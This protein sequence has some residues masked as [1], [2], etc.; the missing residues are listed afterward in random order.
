MN[1]PISDN[2]KAILL[3][4]APLLAGGGQRNGARILTISEYNQLARL[5]QERNA[6]PA[7]LLSSS[8]PA[9]LADLRLRFDTRRLDELLAR[10]FLL[11][12]AVETWNSR[13][14]RVA[15][16]ADPDYPGRF[17]VRLGLDAPPVLYGC[18]D[19]SLLDSGGLAVVGSR[20]VDEK[21]IE[22]A[23]K[24]AST[25]AAAGILVI[26]GG[27]KGID[28]AAMQGSLLAGGRAIGIVAD[29]LGQA[30]VARDSRDPIRE[31]RLTL[32][33]P[34]DPAAGFNVGNAMQ[35]NKLIYALADVA[36]V[37]N[38][39]HEKGGTWSGAIEQIERFRA[40]PVFVRSGEDVP[41]GNK[42]LIEAG[43]RP[44]PNPT[45]AKDLISLLRDAPSTISTIS[46][47]EQE[48]FLP[49]L[50]VSEEPLPG[51]SG[52]MPSATRKA[53]VT[54]PALELL[55]AVRAI[56]LRELV[57]PLTQKEI[58]A[59]LGVPEG[60]ASKWLKLL[61]EQGALTKTKRPVRYA[62]RSKQTGAG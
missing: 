17:K 28:R 34:F 52:S 49:G 51:L 45:T 33:S 10:G 60:Q 27:A 30:V 50:R 53:A 16:R 1:A 7:D 38:S 46:N 54:K 18:G 2:T 61:V 47:Q 56:L 39:D 42:K 57:K 24:T 43:A 6:Q 31:K 9:L 5:L 41:I 55:S 19:W 11:S 21:L 37:V 58:A 13:A 36:L 59:L 25:C 15:S 8:A 4:A 48:E 32:I 44:W 20:H 35:R 26:S 12:Q 3:L 22:F 23:R 40:C 29:G 62:A 14:I